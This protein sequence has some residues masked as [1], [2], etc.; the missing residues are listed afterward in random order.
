M[1]EYGSTSIPSSSKR[2]K[3]DNR[4]LPPSVSIDSIDDVL[5]LEL[6]QT[7]PSGLSQEKTRLVLSQGRTRCLRRILLML[8][9]QVPSHQMKM[10]APIVLPFP[11]QSQ[12]RYDLTFR[13]PIMFPLDWLRLERRATP[14]SHDGEGT[15]NCL[16][17]SKLNQIAVQFNLYNVCLYLW[18]F[19]LIKDYDTSK[20]NIP[21]IL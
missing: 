8:G 1:S 18:V 11:R 12:I 4:G 20:N 2:R 6:W 7:N 21:D 9:H 14:Y 3:R 19:L 16:Y 17:R 5:S 13:F 15:V 10:V